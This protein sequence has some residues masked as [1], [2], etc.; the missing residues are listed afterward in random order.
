MVTR[1]RN[2]EEAGRALALLL[3]PLAR[4][5]PVVVAI[6]RGGV[7]VAYEVALAL[8][9]P[10]DVVIVRKL[11]APDEPELAV[12]AIAEGG[13]VYIDA[14]SVQVL[15]ISR[16]E[17]TSIAERESVELRR[18]ARAYRGA[19]PP[20]DLAGRTVILVDDGI[21]RGASAR[22]AIRAV[23][24]RNPRRLVLAVPV[25]APDTV[26]ELRSEVDDLVAV[27]AP[28]H[29]GSVGFWYDD[30]E[31]VTDARVLSL[32]SRARGDPEPRLATPGAPADPE[33]VSIPCDAGLLQ[34]TLAVPPHATGLV[35]FARGSRGGRANA[36]DQHV[37][38]KLREAGLA[39][40]LLD[41]L[42]AREE[43]EDEVSAVH[44]ADIAKL[45]G[46]LVAVALWATSPRSLRALPV[47]YFA[48]GSGAAAALQAAA[49][50]PHLV[51]A[52]VSRGGRPD[53]AGQTALVRARA[54]TL[55]AVG[56]KD[57]EVLAL[58]RSAMASLSGE[59]RLS[60]VPG[61]SHLFEEA[62][63][64]DAVARISAAWFRRHLI[65]VPM[66][67]WPEGRLP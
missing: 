8:D 18:R 58:N 51:R 19:R 48:S 9:A 26:H 38:R 13:S 7:P 37:A 53:L 6:P 50:L 57:P 30:F 20:R 65:A 25:I 22:A 12:G 43:V 42:T 52:V 27:A 28:Y 23:R 10:L 14:E 60:V 44:R 45:A 66:H 59:R 4:E 62:G 35:I 39:T 34:G 5:S 54:A 17:L 29:F 64:L 3:K 33:D 36:S 1:F 24:E 41:L 40:L 31:Q 11:G 16:E 2:R 47:G 61:A 55:L 21:A 46:R 67:P 15:D 56:A 32:L 63:T 49:E